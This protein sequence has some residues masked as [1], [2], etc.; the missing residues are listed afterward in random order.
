MWY[1]DWL[2]GLCYARSLQ[3]LTSD[4]FK[5]RN[6]KVGHIN[7][8]GVACQSASL[9]EVEREGR[10]PHFLKFL[11]P[12]MSLLYLLWGQGSGWGVG[13]VVWIPAFHMESSKT[14]HQWHREKN[15]GVYL[16]QTAPHFLYVPGSVPCTDEELWTCEVCFPHSVWKS[17]LVTRERP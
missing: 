11:I 14:W 16:L 4:L 3:D 2:E 6:G 15:L 13:Q 10:V 5:V 8:P 1:Q 9:D 7:A 17:G 12:S